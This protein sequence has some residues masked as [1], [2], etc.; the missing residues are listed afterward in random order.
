MAELLS[1]AGIAGTLA[2]NHA[3]GTEV[4]DAFGLEHIATGK[5]DRLHVCRQRRADRRA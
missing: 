3:S 5:A 4:I 2:N 1:R